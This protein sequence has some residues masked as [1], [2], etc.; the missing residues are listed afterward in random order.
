MDR[1][2][3]WTGEP[4]IYKR[5]NG[6]G[7]VFG[8]YQYLFDGAGKLESMQTIT[9]PVISA[10]LSALYPNPGA[11]MAAHL[12]SAPVKPEAPNEQ[13]DLRPGTV[14]SQT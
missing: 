3:F 4:L 5:P 12:K 11:M 6:I 14:G 8:G 2:L 7:L 13:R 10:I 1:S 9:R